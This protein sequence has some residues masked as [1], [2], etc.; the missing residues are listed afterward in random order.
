MSWASSP[1]V[2]KVLLDND[3][4]VTLFA[5]SSL[6]DSSYVSPSGLLFFRADLSNS[7]HY[8]EVDNINAAGLLG[9]DY[10][11]IFSITGGTP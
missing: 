8:L 6:T 5:N 2:Y 4:P 7:S 11:E 3:D 9:L 1:T 10:I